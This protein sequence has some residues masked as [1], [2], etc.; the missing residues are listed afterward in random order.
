MNN[1]TFFPIVPGKR[2]KKPRRT[3]IGFVEMPLR[4]GAV[5]KIHLPNGAQIETLCVIGINEVSSDV[6]SY[7]TSD[8]F[9]TVRYQPPLLPNCG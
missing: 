9:Y 4:V 2:P 6:V 5:S 8:T 3:L 7:E 1:T